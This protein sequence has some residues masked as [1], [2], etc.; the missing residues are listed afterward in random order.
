MHDGMPVPKVIDFGIAK[1][2]QHELTEQTVFTLYGQF[3]GTPSY[4][5]PEQAEMSGLDIDTRSDIYSLGVLLYEL[6]TGRPPLDSN[7]LKK[8]G[9]DEIRRRIREDEPAKPSTHLSTLIAKELFVLARHRK[10]DPRKLS[11]NIRG[12]LD[13]IVMKALEKDRNR[14]YGTPNELAA[15]LQHFLKDEPVSAVA[16][17]PLHRFQKLA[18]RHKTAF[19][20]IVAFAALVLLGSALSIWLA[21]RAT[22]AEAIADQR[23][24]KER[25][26]RESE[27]TQR[28]RAELNEKAAIESQKEAEASQV[29][30]Q[31][32]LYYANIQLAYRRIEEGDIE[33][34]LTN[35]SNCPPKYRHWE[36]GR[37]LYL[38]HQEL[39]T[40]NLD[41]TQIAEIQFSPGDEH[42]ATVGEDGQLRILRRVDGRELWAY[43]GEANRVESIAF[44][45][46]GENIAFINGKGAIEVWDSNRWRQRFKIDPGEGQAFTALVYGRKRIAA[47]EGFSQVAWFAADKGNRLRTFECRPDELVYELSI[48]YDERSIVA[49]STETLQVWR[50]DAQDNILST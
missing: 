31:E 18:R 26:A 27:F 42:I 4:M 49:T 38:C 30:A 19:R 47:I 35:L 44:H 11:Q 46:D 34:A 22:K 12:D 7:E 9:Y 25:I 20:S 37:L 40:R 43:E 48:G 6:L 13:W 15:D 21:I 41:G 8:S 29:L 23:A 32:E 28:Q 36:W 5:S 45:P 50:V 14:R 17:S 2:T 1:A 16:P 10:T 33:G 3:I 39:W 24:E